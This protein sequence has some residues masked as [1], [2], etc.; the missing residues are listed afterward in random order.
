MGII[1]IQN[2]LSWIEPSLN[3]ISLYGVSYWR[4]YLL[5]CSVSLL[6]L[7]HINMFCLLCTNIST[8]LQ[9]SI[10]YPIESCKIVIYFFKHSQIFWS[11]SKARFYLIN[12]HIWAWS[13]IFDHIQKILNTVKN[14][15]TWS[16]GIWTSRWIR[17]MIKTCHKCFDQIWIILG[18][19]FD[20]FIEWKNQSERC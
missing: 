3:T 10:F 15:W 11:W 5:L 14:I 9:F 18:W 7:M 16:K 4:H 19:I 12:L 2:K 6:A 20:S 8:I 17:H 13:K 1:Q